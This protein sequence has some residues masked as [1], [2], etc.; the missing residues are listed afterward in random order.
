M[1]GRAYFLIDNRVEFYYEEHYLLGRNTLQSIKL[2][3]PASQCLHALLI[4][5]G[6]IVSQTDLMVAGWGNRSAH[7]SVNT[8]Y[9]SILHLRRSIEFIGLEKGFIK[10]VNRKGL[11]VHKGW[12]II[13][14]TESID[15]DIAENKNTKQKHYNS[16]KNLMSKYGLILSSSM[17]FFFGFAILSVV[18]PRPAFSNYNL[19]SSGNIPVSCAIYSN[20][21]NN[22]DEKLEF[23]K[24][25]P[26]LCEKYS[27][28]YISMN[29]ITK[30]S[31]IVACDKQ[32]NTDTAIR[33]KSFYFPE[34]R[35]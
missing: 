27:L 1:S 12:N 33:C 30:K 8:Y 34:Y 32:I 15:C 2:Q 5:H 25:H 16:I 10:T 20:Q 17:M 35:K 18:N 24:A 13:N 28:L 14:C 4:N 6:N 7:I 31:S 23:L 3:V 9:Q 21:D 29:T 11:L 22:F 19:I 26:N